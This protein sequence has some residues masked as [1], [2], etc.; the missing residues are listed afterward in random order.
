M[1]GQKL[2]EEFQRRRKQ[3]L[4]KSVPPFLMMI[5]GFSGFYFLNGGQRV[6][7]DVPTEQFLKFLLAMS[8]AG[9]GIVWWTLLTYKTYRCPACN[10]VPMGGWFHAGSAGIGFSRGVNMNPDA[11]PKC[12]VQLK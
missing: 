2:V 6:V 11:C 4:R 5:V 9:G 3:Y 8:I 1:D 10:E 7:V 12:G